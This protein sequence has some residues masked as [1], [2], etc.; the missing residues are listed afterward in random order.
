L[1]EILKWNFQNTTYVN[2]AR[3][4]STATCQIDIQK[5]LNCSILNIGE[6]IKVQKR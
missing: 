2:A 4:I 1:R 5:P 6:A 3:I